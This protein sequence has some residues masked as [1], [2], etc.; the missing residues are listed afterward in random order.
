MPH[1]KTISSH[2]WISFMLFNFLNSL[3]VDSARFCW[4]FALDGNWMNKE[5]KHHKIKWHYLKLVFML[6][7][8]GNESLITIAREGSLQRIIRRWM[9]QSH[10]NSKPFPSFPQ[11]ISIF[12]FSHFAT[13]NDSLKNPS[14]RYREM[15]LEIGGEPRCI[16]CQFLVQGLKKREGRYR[17][18][19]HKIWSSG[20][21]KT[22][23]L[24]FLARYQNWRHWYRD[25][26]T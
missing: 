1:P 5:E 23:S 19:C 9:T 6:S 24:V 10:P 4:C 8:E 14:K 2:G 16:F 21:R 17:K 25:G 15:W 12:G 13:T 11:F 26:G 3:S 22:F 18:K 7:L 20:W